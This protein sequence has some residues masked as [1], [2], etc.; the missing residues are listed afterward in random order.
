MNHGFKRG[1]LVC[2][3]ILVMISLC[4]CGGSS[5]YSSSSYSEPSRNGY[6]MPNSSDKNVADYIQR[7]APDLWEDMES[8]WD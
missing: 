3:L 6:D 7:V 8:N 5:S 2:L 4:A 1:A